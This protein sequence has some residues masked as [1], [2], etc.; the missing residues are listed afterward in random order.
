MS[1]LYA[2]YAIFVI[3]AVIIWSIFV[4]RQNSLFKKWV[5]DHWF[6]KTNW[7]FKISSACQIIAVGLIAFALLDLRG[8]EKFVR[9]STSSQ[10]TMILIDTSASMFVEDV[11]PNR[12]EK[13]LLLVKHYVKRA[14]G[15]KISIAV[16]SDYPKKIVPFTDDIDLIEARIESLK[17]LNLNSGGTSLSLAIGEAIQNFKMTEGDSSGNILVFTDAEETDGGMKLEVPDSISVGVVGV[18]TRRGGPVPVRNDRGIFIKNKTYQGETVISKL[19]ESFLESFGQ[20]IKYYK[21]WVATSYTLPT[22]EILNFFGR[23]H[24]IKLSKNN[25][26]IRPVEA[27]KLLI[28]AMVLLSLG[29]F[30]K[31]FKVFSTVIL[32]ITMSN[33]SYAQ[34]NVIDPQTLAQIGGEQEKKEPV[35]SPETLELEK[36]FAEGS[37]DDEGVRYLAT[38]LMQDGFHEDASALYNEIM[39]EEINKDNVQH[40]F[41]H[42]SSMLLGK[43]NRDEAVQKY[44]NIVDYLEKN[45]VPN[46]EE[47]RKK[48][49]LNMLKAFKQSQG[50]GGKSDEDKKEKDQQDKND[51]SQDKKDDGKEGEKK[52][53]QK[54]NNDE[55][56][57]KK[58][59]KDMRK[60]DSGD[61][62]ESKE[63]KKERQKKLPA[64][65][66]QLMSDDNKLQKKMIDAKTT[67]RKSSEQKDW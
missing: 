55:D 13:A 36:K 5:V 32:L 38:K 30:L 9:A 59:E 53:D 67:K 41:N 11:R 62:E 50:G 8:P 57:K 65:L 52:K 39:P 44:K 3:I 25:Y 23:S 35:K 42:A 4:L 19:D 1:F 46:G 54:K 63:E 40:K 31:Q 58:P 45:D 22:D 29:Y 61:K 14:Y 66:K 60:K 6:I 18:G 48:A 51:K 15:Q 28:P 43:G 10:K 20:G 24:Q 7:K 33:F 26:R 12:F 64:L 16:F 2:Q 34:M 21:H 17:E 27:W 56:K 49:K 37:L 47:M